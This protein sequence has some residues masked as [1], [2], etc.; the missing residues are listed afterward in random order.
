MKAGREGFLRGRGSFLL[1]EYLP[2][3]SKRFHEFANRLSGRYD[4]VTVET[5]GL[6]NV[7]CT[8]CFQSYNRPDHLG[9]MTF[10]NFRRLIELNAGYLRTKR[11]GIYLHH[12]GEALL[13]ERLLDMA[14]FAHD[15]G[16]SL[17]NLHTNLNVEWDEERLRRL[18]ESPFPLIIVNVGGTTPQ[19]HERVMQGSRFDR[20]TDNLRRMLRHPGRDRVILKMNVTKDNVHQIPELPGLFESLGGNPRKIWVWK[21]LFIE[22]AEASAEA[23]AAYLERNVSDANA[24]YLKFVYSDPGD[25]RSMIDWCRYIIPTV[26]WDGQVSLCCQDKHG[27]FHLGNAFETPLQRI[28]ESSA[29]RSAE[30]AGR[31]KEYWFCEGCN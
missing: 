9:L 5:S 22:P 31:R 12:R 25:V 15:A 23:R 6:C 1:Q 29:Y 8:W 4:A 20:V 24:D 27:R 18:I 16:V 21:L 28:V 3:L 11:T 26:R 19:V 2:A 7:R 10:D 17:R 14:S 30:K 13:N